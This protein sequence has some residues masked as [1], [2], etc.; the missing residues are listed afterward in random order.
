MTRGEIWWADLPDHESSEPGYRRPVLI[1]QSD[2]FN[3]SKI[4][5]IICIIINSNLKISEAPGNVLIKSNESNLPIDS[6]IN[7]SQIITLD[8]K[9]FTDCAGSVKRSTM[10]KVE[11]GIKLVLNLE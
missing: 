10:K 6:V 11:N 5:T 1:I 9:F 2:H 8:K 4:N 3:R 7:I